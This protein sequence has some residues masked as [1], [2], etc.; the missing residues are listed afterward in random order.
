MENKN[1]DGNTNLPNYLLNMKLNPHF[2]L[3]NVLIQ[4]V[5]PKI[6]SYKDQHYLLWYVCNAGKIFNISYAR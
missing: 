6:I 1:T 3:K 5:V 2:N 4:I